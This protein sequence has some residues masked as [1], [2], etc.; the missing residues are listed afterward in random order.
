MKIITANYKDLEKHNF[1]I[2]IFRI[3][4]VP[5]L[6]NLPSSLIKKI[7]KRSN[8]DAADV[9]DNVGSAKAMEVIYAKYKNKPFSEGFVRGITNI[10]W[11]HFLSQPKGLRNRLKIV[12]NVIERE[13]ENII[14][15]KESR[16]VIKILTVGGGSGRSVMH[17]LYKIIKEHNYKNVKIFNLDKS[18]QSI[19]LSKQAAKEYNMR[20][21]FEWINDDA[22]NIKSLFSDDSMDIIE[23]I[24][25]LDY[26]SEEQGIQIIKQIYNILKKGGVFI[27]S[28]IHPNSEMSFI[29]KTGWPKLYYRTPEQIADILEESGFFLENGE[30]VIE[31]LKN[32]IIAVIKK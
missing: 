26:L 10:F 6:N 4:S 24:G 5:L 16:E 19:T 30:I 32:H 20:N 22:K 29:Y 21:N 9:V 14:D 25:L 13:V 1:W 31:P 7:M 3:F 11:H 27:V 2:K 12:Q 8:R 15:H 17:P 28:N 23:M 18:T